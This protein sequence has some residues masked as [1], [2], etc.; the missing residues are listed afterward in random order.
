MIQP[1]TIKQAESYIEDYESKINRINEQIPKVRNEIDRLKKIS[2]IIV[3]ANYEGIGIQRYLDCIDWMCPNLD[4]A[5]IKMEEHRG[6]LTNNI[7]EY[8]QWIVDKKK[9]TGV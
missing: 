9:N 8:K 6:E 3:E 5:I 7:G 2:R 4:N 1:K